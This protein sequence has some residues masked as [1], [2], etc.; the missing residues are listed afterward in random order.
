MTNIVEQLK[1]LITGNS[2]LFTFLGFIFGIISL[3]VAYL[4]YKKSKR[5]IKLSAII[6]TYQLTQ[7]GVKI[8]N[9][10]DIFYKGQKINT[11]CVSKVYIENEGTE[12]ITGDKIS[13]ENPLIIKTEDDEEILDYEITYLSNNASK[14]NLIKQD[15]NKLV[16]V[17]DYLNARDELFINIIHTSQ[18][19]NIFVDGSIIGQKNNISEKSKTIESPTISDRFGKQRLLLVKYKKLPIFLGVFRILL[20][21]GL[22][23]LCFFKSFSWLVSVLLILWGIIWIYNGFREIIYFNKAFKRKSRLR[24]LMIRPFSPSYN[25][26]LENIFK[27]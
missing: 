10:L 9:D 21:I 2:N 7:K 14:V 5:I 16:V 24:F 11:F 23:A 6:R 15:K 26:E 12:E 27:D 18:S 20:G 3:I 17:F 4:F 22:I 1:H 19:G 8:Y 13:K 25:K